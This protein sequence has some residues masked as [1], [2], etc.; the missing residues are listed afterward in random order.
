[1]QIFHFS[2]KEREN[3]PIAQTDISDNLNQKG[4]EIFSATFTLSE[5]MNSIGSLPFKMFHIMYKMINFKF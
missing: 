2:Y 1:M 4:K 5:T 3:M